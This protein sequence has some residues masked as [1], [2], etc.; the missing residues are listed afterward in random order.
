VLAKPVFEF[1]G[2]VLLE[3]PA[4]MKDQ[5]PLVPGRFVGQ[6]FPQRISA[7]DEKLVSLV[8]IQVP[9]VGGQYDSGVFGQLST[10][11][12]DFC[13]ESLDLPVCV[14]MTRPEFVRRSVNGW[15]ENV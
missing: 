6:H 8:K 5:A 11:P 2:K 4:N 12:A 14:G 15:P 10:Q 13:V 1:G 7:L 9:V 3:S